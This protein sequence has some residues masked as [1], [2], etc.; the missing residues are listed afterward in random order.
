MTISGHFSHLPLR[1]RRSFSYQMV[2]QIA[3][4]SAVAHD[5]AYANIVGLCPPV[6]F[7]VPVDGKCGP[8][9]CYRPHRLLFGVIFKVRSTLSRFDCLP[10]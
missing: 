5:D 8:S 3:H 2:T 10:F 1:L 4:F 9:N 7:A 6:A